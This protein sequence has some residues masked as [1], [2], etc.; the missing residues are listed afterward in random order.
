MQSNV[1]KMAYFASTHAACV[2][3]CMQPNMSSD[4]VN[5]YGGPR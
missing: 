1:Y 2:P 3:L 4:R 5:A